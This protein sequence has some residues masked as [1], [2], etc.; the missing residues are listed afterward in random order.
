MSVTFF[1]LC[2]LA[3][4]AITA[5]QFWRWSRMLEALPRHCGHIAGVALMISVLLPSAAVWLAWLLWGLLTWIGTATAPE[6][7]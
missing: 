6:A 5:I 3:P 2:G 4:A 7:P 1:L